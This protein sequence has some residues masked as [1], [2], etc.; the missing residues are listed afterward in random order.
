MSSEIVL[1]RALACEVDEIA[2]CVRGLD[3]SIERIGLSVHILV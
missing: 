1:E 2:E 3:Q